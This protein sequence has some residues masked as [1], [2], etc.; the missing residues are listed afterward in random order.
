MQ[1]W[2]NVSMII[3]SLIFRVYKEYERIGAVLN[4]ATKQRYM[5]KQALK[6]KW[7]WDEWN[8]NEMKWN[9]T[10]KKWMQVE[11]EKIKEWLHVDWSTCT[12]T[13]Y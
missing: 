11:R 7:R 3:N 12:D 13:S 6:R 2:I 9:E 1:V 8:E 4:R 10:R 5:Y